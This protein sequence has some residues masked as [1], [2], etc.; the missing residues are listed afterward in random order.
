MRAWLVF[1][2]LFAACQTKWDE[3]QALLR[4]LVSGYVRST[5]FP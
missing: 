3:V 1:A 2:L 4:H 5:A